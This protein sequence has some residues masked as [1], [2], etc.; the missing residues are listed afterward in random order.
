[1][2]GK[3]RR[4]NVSKMKR[5]T[6]IIFT[7][8]EEEDTLATKKRGRKKKNHVKTS[9][10]NCDSKMGPVRRKENAARGGG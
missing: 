9:G 1:M 8:P 6:R 7:S 10:E 2:V 3:G 5:T 4:M